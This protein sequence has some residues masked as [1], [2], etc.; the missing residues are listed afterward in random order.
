MS[1]FL[2]SP[3]TTMSKEEWLN[4]LKVEAILFYKKVQKDAEKRLKEWQ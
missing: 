4:K 1:K 2:E 3:T